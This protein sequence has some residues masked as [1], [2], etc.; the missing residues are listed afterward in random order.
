M[1]ELA[2]LTADEFR[3]GLVTRKIDVTHHPQAR[4]INQLRLLECGSSLRAEKAN[5]G[6]SKRVYVRALGAQPLDMTDE[7]KASLGKRFPLC[8]GS[9]G[10]G[11]VLFLAESAA[12]GG[13]YVLLLASGKARQEARLDV[14]LPQCSSRPC[15]LC[16]V[17]VPQACLRFSAPLL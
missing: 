15:V 10:L 2:D 1:K 5:G 17:G 9:P 12:I 8:S 3:L 11:T 6:G 4:E 14:L 7:A 13:G 16:N